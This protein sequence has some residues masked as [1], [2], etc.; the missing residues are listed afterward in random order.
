MLFITFEHRPVTLL[1]VDAGILF[2][3]VTTF[4]EQSPN[5]HACIAE[6]VTNF[7]FIYSHD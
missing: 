7:L 4:D 6:L 3:P 5:A 1:Y 2:I